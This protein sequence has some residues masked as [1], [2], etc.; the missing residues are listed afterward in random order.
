MKVDKYWHQANDQAAK[1]I[2]CDLCPRHCV[3]KEG[4]RGFCFI[5]ANVEGKLE[6]TSYGRSSGFCIDPIEKKPLNHF[7]PGTPVLSCGTAGCNLGCKFCQNWDMSKSRQMDRLM[8]QATPEQ[9]ALSAKKM[10]CKSLAYTYNDPII[11]MEYAVD[12]AMAAHELGIKSVAVTAG[13][14]NPKPAEEFFSHMDAANIDLKSF[15]E[16]FYKTHCAGELQP[17][18]E[19]LLYV[20]NET[21]VWLEITTLLIPGLN[22]SAQEIDKLS[23]WIADKLGAHIPVHFSAFHPSWKVQNIPQTPASTVKQARE[24]AMKNG[25]KYVYTGNIHDPTGASTYC[26]NCKKLLIA[27]DWYELSIWNL[28]PE[29]A[30]NFCGQSIPGIFDGPPGDWGSKRHPIQING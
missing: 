11:F 21:D 16:D 2:I 9:L 4:M 20:K 25:L 30:C 3:L 1:T 13:Y 23:S 7:L 17:V 14:I 10:G 15:S 29:G 26:H 8:D 19:T 12:T 18:L 24:I 27:R 22:D 5:R 28:S 6:L